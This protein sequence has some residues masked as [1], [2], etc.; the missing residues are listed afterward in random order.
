MQIVKA[1]ANCHKVNM[2]SL[3]AP[4][5]TNLFGRMGLGGYAAQAVSHRGGA[6]Q[7]AVMMEMVFMV[8]YKNPV[9]KMHTGTS[10]Y[11]CKLSKKLSIHTH[12]KC[13]AG[14]TSLCAQLA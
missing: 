7:V 4:L 14:D 5:V 6:L 13:L 3:E 8:A 2:V 12:A 11:L 9:S 1:F 10:V